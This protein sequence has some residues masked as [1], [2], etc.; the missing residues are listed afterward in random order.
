MDETGAEG[1]PE[2]VPDHPGEPGFFHGRNEY[3]L[4]ECISI[5]R[6]RMIDGRREHP[7]GEDDLTS[8]QIPE[9]GK[10]RIVQGNVP[11]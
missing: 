3:F 1:M 6:F 7:R 5:P 9:D 2:A 10:G 11:G 8:F 4:I